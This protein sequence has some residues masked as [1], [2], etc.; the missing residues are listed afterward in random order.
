MSL[1]RWPVGTGHPALAQTAV[2]KDLFTGSSSLKCPCTIGTP[3]CA[4]AWRTVP[5][6]TQSPPIFMA[7][8]SGNANAQKVMLGIQTFAFSIFFFNVLVLMPIWNRNRLCFEKCMEP[9][10]KFPFNGSPSPPPLAV[11]DVQ[12]HIMKWGLFQEGNKG[13][14]AQLSL[15]PLQPSPCF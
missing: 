7:G 5:Y 2:T 13:S 12:P 15:W 3:K 11:K 8:E 4:K 9:K 1:K 14:T 6:P 10:L